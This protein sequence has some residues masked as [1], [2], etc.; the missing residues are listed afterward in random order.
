MLRCPSELNRAPH[1]GIFDRRGKRRDW[2]KKPL[3][4]RLINKAVD[5][6]HEL[7]RRKI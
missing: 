7:F 2:A 4:N 3:I 1:C 5:P 6:G